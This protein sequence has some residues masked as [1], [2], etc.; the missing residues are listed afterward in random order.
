MDTVMNKNLPHYV[1]IDKVKGRT[2][3]LPLKL[4][5]TLDKICP[6]T[7]PL[8]TNHEIYIL[9]RGNPTKG[10]LIWEDYVDIK[11]ICGMLCIG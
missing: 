8:N 11:K 5:P 3:H 7:D 6:E 9:V 10:K 1:K 4:G 2:F